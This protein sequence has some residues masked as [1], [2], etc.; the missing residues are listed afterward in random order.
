MNSTIQPVYGQKVYS[1]IKKTKQIESAEADTAKATHTAKTD[2]VIISKAVRTEPVKTADHN[3]EE[4]HAVIEENALAAT[5]ETKE[6]NEE[7]SSKTQ[8]GSV[9]VNASKR[10]RQIAAAKNRNQVQQVLALL[11]Q[12]MSDCKAGLEKGWC[13]E[14]EIAKV[15]ALLNAAKGKLSQVPQESEEELGIS[16]FDIASIM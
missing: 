10:A 12:D 6:A 7:E 11:N 8:G 1:S 5:E 15:Q 9:A 13:D 3:A 4:N 16:E 2:T 14:T